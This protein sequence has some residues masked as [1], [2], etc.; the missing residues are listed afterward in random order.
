MSAALAPISGAIATFDRDP[1]V[2]PPAADAT[3]V[4]S[5]LSGPGC[6][7]FEAGLADAT[8]R[9]EALSWTAPGGL[10]VAMTARNAMGTDLAHSFV[11]ALQPLLALNDDRRDSLST[12]LQEALANAV[13]HGSLEMSGLSR[14]SAEAFL[15]FSAAMEERLAN[16]A[17]GGRPIFMAARWSADEVEIMVADRGKGYLPEDLAARPWR[18]ASGRGLTLIAEL[19]DGV[20]FAE[21]GRRIFMRFHR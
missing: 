13:M 15:Q 6:A 2:L 20:T 16:P 17:Y 8:L 12:A 11:E 9:A 19:A 1:A 4:R 5:A 7:A 10:F 21:R 18:D 14:E 3:A